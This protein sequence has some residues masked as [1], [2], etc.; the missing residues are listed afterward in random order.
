M[1]SFFG[2]GDDEQFGFSE[3]AYLHC[4]DFN[5]VFR[6]LINEKFSFYYCRGCL[7]M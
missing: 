7:T 4:A 3:L 2:D 6:E 1:T 5:V